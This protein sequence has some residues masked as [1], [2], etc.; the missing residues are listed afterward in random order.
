MNAR[1]LCLASVIVA[2]L[3]CVDISIP[4]A[5]LAGDFSVAPIRLFLDKDSRSGVVTVKNNGT[6]PLQF[7]L[8][9]KQWG[10]GP[11]G[12]ELYS[13][14]ID[15]L[16]FPRLMTLRGGEERDIRIGMK[17]PAGQ[18][19]K[20]YRVFINELPPTRDP[21]SSSGGSANVAFL[22]NFGLPVFFA[23]VAPAPALRVEHLSLK[24]GQVGVWL[25]NPGNVHQFVQEMAVIGFDSASNEVFRAPINDRYLL[26]GTVRSYTATVPLEGCKAL[27]VVA[28]EVRTDKMSANADKSVDRD[29]CNSGNPES[30]S[31]EYSR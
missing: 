24:D 16:V 13:E 2:V 14:T 27:A 21:E 1:N 8:R 11:D 26:A 29:F 28:F 7:E 20:T 18:A 22:I 25:E 19:E 31:A 30:S 10:T 23:P 17:V 6:E 12:R 3:A 4:R 9:P 5:A 15:L